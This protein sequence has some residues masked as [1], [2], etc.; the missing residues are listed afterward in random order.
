MTTYD[1]QHCAKLLAHSEVKIWI[2]RQESGMIWI[3]SHPITKNVDWISVLTTKLIDHATHLEYIN[4][5]RHFSLGSYSNKTGSSPCIVV[6][7]LIFQVLSRNRR[8]FLN[9]QSAGLVRQRFEDARH[10]LKKLWD[11]FIEVIKTAKVRCAWIVLD[12]VDILA[13]Q[14]QMGEVLAFLTCLD[15]LVQKK[16]ITVKVF[17]TARLCGSHHL[18]SH[19]GESGAISPG[20]P[21]INVPR[22]SHRHEAL[23]WARYSNRPHRLQQSRPTNSR[24]VTHLSGPDVDAF[25][26]SSDDASDYGHLQDEDVTRSTQAPDRREDSPTRSDVKDSDSASSIGDDMLL[27][28]EAETTNSESPKHRNQESNKLCYSSSDDGSDDECLPLPNNPGVKRPFGGLAW[29]SDS[30]DDFPHITA[31]HAPQIVVAVPTA[32][33]SSH[34]R[35]KSSLRLKLDQNSAGSAPKSNDQVSDVKMTK[36]TVTFDSDYDESDG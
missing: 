23:L 9:N 11:I 36:K 29:S 33:T 4:V 8:Q 15:T 3:N 14:S 1:F 5:L 31:P 7:S 24:D 27:F 28:S 25:G 10:D 32:S 18:S 30:D 22:G 12:H 6:Q 21:I 35:R 20:H 2:E 34:E 16:S 26:I 19:A 17:I 13:E